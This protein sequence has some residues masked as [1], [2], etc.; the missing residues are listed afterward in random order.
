MI[1]FRTYDDSPIEI[2]DT[3]TEVWAKG[4]RR[5]LTNGAH[6][7]E[8]WRN[9]K[10]EKFLADHEGRT[11]VAD[12]ITV[13]APKVGPAVDVAVAVEQAT[14]EKYV[15]SPDEWFF[16]RIVHTDQDKYLLLELSTG[17]TVY[18]PWQKVTQSP[19]KH[20]KCLPPG[21]ECAIRMILDH[22]V[23]WASEMRID[24]TAKYYETSKARITTWNGLGGN[25]YRECGCPIFVL[26]HPPINSST[27]QVG[28]QVEIS[29]RPSEKR[30]WVGFIQ[31]FITEQ[32]A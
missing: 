18:C 20:S 1:E 15:P 16:A 23:Y 28:D 29:I 32:A 27:V 9:R 31:R 14:A 2:A 19:G 11:I 5:L 26:S 30:G 13:E 4:Y 25:A 3:Y 17:D 12:V 7:V 10:R 21:T 22:N 8:V 24:D 6:S